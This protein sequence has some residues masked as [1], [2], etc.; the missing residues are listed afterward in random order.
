MSIPYHEDH[1]TVTDGMPSSR[2][3]VGVVRVVVSAILITA[4]IARYLAMPAGSPYVVGN[5]WGSLGDILVIGY[6]IRCLIALG[7]CQGPLASPVVDVLVLSMM[8]VWS[9]W[10]FLAGARSCGCFGSMEVSPLATLA[11]DLVAILSLVTASLA[12][13]PR[14]FVTPHSIIRRAAFVCTTLLF[15]TT[16]PIG[17]QV[18]NSLGDKLPSRPA[19][20]FST[21]ENWLG[22]RFPLIDDLDQP[23]SVADGHRIAVL[24]SANCS[25]C[26]QMLTRIRDQW[27]SRKLDEKQSSEPQGIVI[28]MAGDARELEESIIPASFAVSALRPGH[29]WRIPVPQL[30][31]LRDGIVQSVRGEVGE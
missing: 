12:D 9:A 13:H 7:S 15:A 24:V 2:S 3:M 16:I 6:A 21:P 19:T 22:E 17:Y 1:A 29:G 23:G 5:V 28:V 30:V 8:G 10:S 18:L 20:S 14:P 31:I 25:H 11:F 26:T 27:K 4:V